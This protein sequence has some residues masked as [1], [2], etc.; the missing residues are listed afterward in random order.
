MALGQQLR[1]R[2]A[3]AHGPA[4]AGLH[5]AHEEDPHGD[6]EQH[7][8]PGHEH[9]EQRRHVV[10]R[11]LGGDLHALL[12]QLVD[13]AGIVRRVGLEAA[14]VVEMAADLATGDG[15]ILDAAALD[16]GEKLREANLIAADVNAR[17]LEQVEQGDQQQADEYP[18]GEVAKIRIHDDPS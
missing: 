17:A 6:K 15:H 14:P 9:A 11:R 10:L 8:E 18:D 3:E 13:E 4:A 12:V 1:L 7:R 2:L 16:L 5:L